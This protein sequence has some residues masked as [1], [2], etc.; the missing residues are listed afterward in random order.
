MHISRSG[1][2]GGGLRTP[3]YGCAHS[4]IGRGQAASRAA[5]RTRPN[6]RG[7]SAGRL[8]RPG[9]REQRSGGGADAS[10]TGGQS[11]RSSHAHGEPSSGLASITSFFLLCVGRLGRFSKAAE[12]GSALRA[13][14]MSRYPGDGCQ[15]LVLIAGRR[16]GRFGLRRALRRAWRGRWGRFDPLRWDCGRNHGQGCP[17]LIQARAAQM[18]TRARSE[19]VTEDSSRWLGEATRNE[20]TCRGSRAILTLLTIYGTI[21]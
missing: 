11:R 7:V 14:V 17:G 3:A 18:P 13:G 1:L 15:G 10:P 19:A 21:Q 8:Y 6:A 2:G 4:G 5:S 12:A 9:G 20:Q 16:A